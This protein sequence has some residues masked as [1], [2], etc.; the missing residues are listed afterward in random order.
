MNK[1]EYRI[2]KNKIIRRRNK[3][4]TAAFTLMVFSWG[5]YIGNKL[6][7]QKNTEQNAVVA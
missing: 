3:I 6:A 4:L 1:Y 2:K 5:F 7:S